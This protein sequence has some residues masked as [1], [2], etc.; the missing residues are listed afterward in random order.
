MNNPKVGDRVRVKIRDPKDYAHGVAER[1]EGQLGEVIEVKA[2][3]MNGDPLQ[4]AP[5]YGPAALIR[6]DR[7]VA[8][9]WRGGSEQRA[10]WFPPGDLEAVTA[11]G[12]AP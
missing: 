5:W 11:E 4:A 7:P 3:S 6:Y 9:A 10:A 8:P 12:A 1:L 2:I